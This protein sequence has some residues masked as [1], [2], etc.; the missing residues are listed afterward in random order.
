[1]SDL[2]AREGAPPLV[3]VIVPAYQAEA[4]LDE[5]LE[6]VFAQDYAEYEVILVDDGS[7]DRTAEIAAA[8]PVRVLR[9]ANRGP[10]AAR[11]AGVAVARG[12]L[13][14]I[15]DADDLWPPR[16][17]SRQVAHLR[18]HPRDGL[19]MGLTEAFVTPGQD[20]PAHYPPVADAGPYPGHHCTMLVR[21]EVFDLIG[22]FD[23]SLRLS[24]D[25]DWLAR[26]GDAGVQIGRLD[27]TLLRYRVHAGNTSRDPAANY[28]A[29]MRMLRASVQRK[30][31]QV[32]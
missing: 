28:R 6:S 32:A 27:C 30:G 7:T 12:E 3:S 21:R 10:A 22:P 5:A 18:E 20:R 17:L 4:Y 23:E 9:Q 13:L 24:E 26:A 14:A 25:L 8:H 11:N 15:L 2:A 16:R 19:V 1:M 29:T 31:S